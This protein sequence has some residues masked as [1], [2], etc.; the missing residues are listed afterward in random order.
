MKLNHAGF[1]VQNLEEAIELYQ[2]L[3]FTLSRKFEKP[4]PKAQVASM[5]DTNGVGLELWQFAEDHPLNTYIGRHIAFLCDDV[6]ADAKVLTN[7]GFKEVI[8]FT[9]GVVLDYI[10]VQDTEGTVFELAQ[11]KKQ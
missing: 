3:G 8:P 5:K 2:K 7:A 11:E 4:I 6:R 1:T 10:F 9:E